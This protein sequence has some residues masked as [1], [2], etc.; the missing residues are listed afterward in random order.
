VLKITVVTS[1]TSPGRNNEA[2]ADQRKRRQ[3]DDAGWVTGAWIRASGGLHKAFTLRSVLPLRAN[4][5]RFHKFG[6]ITMS[7]QFS[8]IIAAQAQNVSTFSVQ[9][10]DLQKLGERASPLELFH[11]FRL[12]GRPFGPHPHGGFSIISYVYEDSLTG[13]R[14]CDS[15]GNDFVIDPGGM[16]WTQAGSGLMHQEVAADNDRELHGLQAFVNLS[17]KNKLAAPECFGSKG[18][19]GRSSGAVGVTAYASSWERLKEFHRRWS[20]PNRSRFLKSGCGPGSPS[21]CGRVTT[22]F[23]TSSKRGPRSRR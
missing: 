17:P 9:N 18:G 16:V 22:R 15:L 12:R 13:L 20:L 19:T 21:T 8:P 2:V 7:I 6:V 14:S 23:S 5:S 4:G 1:S 10:I 3:S 11:D